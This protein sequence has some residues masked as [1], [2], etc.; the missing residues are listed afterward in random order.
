MP[1]NDDAENRPDDPPHV[2]CINN[3]QAVLGLFRDL[4]D[5]GG[6]GN[7]RVST[8]AFIDHDLDSLAALAP[9][10]IVLDEMWADDG[11]WSLLQMLRMDPRTA[12]RPIVL[13]TGAAP[14]VE[15][16]PGRL[17]D[18]DV[19]VVLKP[20][21]IDVLEDAIAS[22]L[23]PDPAADR[24]W[25]GTPV[26]EERPMGTDNGAA[27]RDDLGD[28]AHDLRSPLAVAMGRVQLIRRRLRRGDGDIAA[29]ESDL[30]AVEAALVRLR[31][32][33]D[34]LDSRRDDR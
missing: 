28:L 24:A 1:A 11:G 7:Y 4:L 5:G 27:N 20:F 6:D 10:P 19:R 15:T 14:E 25:E 8:R 3:D 22:A 12:A 31:L 16:L 33:T 32:L 23:A 30:E 18:L 26:M 2:P 13:C 9:D 29:L 21:N 17:A 34:R